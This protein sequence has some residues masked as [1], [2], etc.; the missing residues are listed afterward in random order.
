MARTWEEAF[1]DS[2]I[3]A[4]AQRI[5]LVAARRRGDEEGEARAL[6]S[7]ADSERQNGKKK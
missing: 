7:I 4:N 3:L 2:K 1:P 6:A 5:A